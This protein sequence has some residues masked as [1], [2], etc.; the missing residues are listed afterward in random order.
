MTSTF[1]VALATALWLLTF[2]LLILIQPGLLLV[3]GVVLF[4]GWQYL[5]NSKPIK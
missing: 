1:I 2:V 5:G 4:C 3:T